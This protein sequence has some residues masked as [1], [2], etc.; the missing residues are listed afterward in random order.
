MSVRGR[1]LEA[2]RKADGRQPLF[3]SDRKVVD[4]IGDQMPAA[5]GTAAPDVVPRGWCCLR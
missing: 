2:N 4:E 3:W 1:S 5:S